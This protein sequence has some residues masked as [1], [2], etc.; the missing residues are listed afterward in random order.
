MLKI[1]D[2]DQQ[3]INIDLDTM[4][5]VD[6]VR[7]FHDG[8]NGGAYEFK[9]YLKNNNANR[10]YEN[11]TVQLGTNSPS[12]GEFN[13]T[14]W[15]VKCLAGESQPSEQEW[16]LVTSGNVLNMQDIGTTDEANT[17]SYYAF[18]VRIYC[19]GNTE[20]QIRSTDTIRVS[21]NEKELGT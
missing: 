9:M 18:W 6:V 12:F 8:K 7:T 10:Y 4:T 13:E 11:I 3:E 2:A 15:S 17:S 5:A 19:P 21:F 1:Y 16:D 20:A 14:G